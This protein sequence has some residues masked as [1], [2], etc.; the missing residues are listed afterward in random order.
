[1]FT[2]L[3]ANCMLPL[4]RRIAADLVLLHHS[5]EAQ[6]TQLQGLAEVEEIADQANYADELRDIRST[7]ADEERR[8]RACLAELAAL[9]VE[10]HVPIDGGVDFPATMNR[11]TVR[12][13]WVPEELE[14]AH[15]HDVG[16]PR[17]MRRRL[18]PRAFPTESIR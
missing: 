7:L 17:E 13:C 12:L 8:F 10:P 4:V 5:I 14:V 6:R 18:D 3:K 2:P 16:Q 15:W 1:M 9:G 11:R